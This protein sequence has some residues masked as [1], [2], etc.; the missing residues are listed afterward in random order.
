MV[1]KVLLV[2]EPEQRDA[3][4][5]ALVAH[6]FD[7]RACVPKEAAKSAADADAIAVA[8]FP[9]DATAPRFVAHLHASLG[10]NAPPVV[11][12]V[13]ADAGARDS[14]LIAGAADVSFGT[15]P[16]ALAARVTAV[17]SP[18]KRSSPQVKLPGNVRAQSGRAWLELSVD[19]FDASGVGLK[20][21]PGLV[22]G[23]LLRMQFP[24][25]QGEKLTWGRAVVADDVTAVRFVARS[26]SEHAL[27]KEA[28]KASL[29]TGQAPADSPTQIV[30]PVMKPEPPAT[31]VPPASSEKDVPRQSHEEELGKEATAQTEA[32]SGESD[33]GS[34]DVEEKST[35]ASA[36]EAQETDDA[37]SMSDGE[38]LEDTEGVAAEEE[39]EAAASAPDEASSDEEVSAEP[40]SSSLSSA[41]SDALKDELGLFDD[42]EIADEKPV[43]EREWPAVAWD[44][45]VSVEALRTAVSLSL[46]SD[47]EGAPSGATVL[48]FLRTTSPIE[49]RV[50]SSD[51]P[52][53]LPPPEVSETCLALRLHCFALLEEVRPP[54]AEDGETGDGNAE[55]V[56]WTVDAEKIDALKLEVEQ[57]RSE[58]QALVDAM[59]AGGETDRFQNANVFANSLNRAFAEVTREAARLKGESDALSG[60]AALLDVAEPG[61]EQATAP[62]RKAKRDEKQTT[63]KTAQTVAFKRRTP[64]QKARQRLVNLLVVLALA[65]GVRIAFAPE[66]TKSLDPASFRG[67]VGVVDIKVPPVGRRPDRAQA[68]IVTVASGWRPEDGSIAQLK[69]SLRDKG[70]DRFVVFTS[71]G[72]FLATGET[73]ANGALILTGG[74]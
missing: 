20:A 27:M 23:Q 32:A 39:D 65:I 46:A 1:A 57:A 48:A 8:A 74:R 72:E 55:R 19:D 37:D 7:V 67:L 6:G 9:A 31:A 17:L 43:V 10:P 71:G 44:T 36:T 58:I 3:L 69:G 33:N 5:E 61:E 40:P 54:E 49:R 30:P 22:H 68:A 51:P 38:S 35:E 16:E 52:S 34:S 56:R 18:W 28:V 2:S 64:Q 70:I 13:V 73:A 12:T 47:V 29:A 63:T 14:A 21:N 66:K 50:F 42:E 53:E 26:E 15:S 60:N 59:V 62:R 11:S 41:I 24:R 25:G 45:K 4:R